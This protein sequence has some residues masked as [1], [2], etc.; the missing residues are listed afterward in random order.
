MCVIKM[1]SLSIDEP[2]YYRPLPCFTPGANSSV[3]EVNTSVRFKTSAPD[4]PLRFDPYTSFMNQIKNGSNVQNGQNKSYS[5]GG[6]PARTLD[7][8]WLPGGR[9]R[10]IRHGWICQD[11]R[12]PDTQHQPI[13]TGTPQY[14]WH[15]KVATVYD[16]KRTGDRFLPLPGPYMLHPSQISRGGNAPRIVDNEDQESQ[17]NLNQESDKNTGF[18]RQTSSKEGFIFPSTLRSS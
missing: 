1:S 11:V 4:M 13:N 10:Y 18:Q 3:G 9:R 7:S 15:N 14:S 16:L 12:A 5:S 8:N 2:Y 6:G 17:L